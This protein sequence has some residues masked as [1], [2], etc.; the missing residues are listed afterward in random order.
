MNILLLGLCN[1]NNNNC[2]RVSL[3]HKTTPVFN[4]NCT[5]VLSVLHTIAPV[6][7]TK[8]TPYNCPSI[9]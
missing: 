1:N 3:P 8:R 9:R 6:F 5:R 7:N 4:N 2:T